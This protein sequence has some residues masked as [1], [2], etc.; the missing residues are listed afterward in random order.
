MSYTRTSFV[1]L[2]IKRRVLSSVDLTLTAFLIVIL[3]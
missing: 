1:H 3:T 2:F